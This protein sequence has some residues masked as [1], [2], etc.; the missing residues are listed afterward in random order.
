M[1]YKTNR[2][3][4]IRAFDPLGTVFYLAGLILIANSIE[5]G[6]GETNPGVIIGALLFIP[7][8]YLSSLVTTDLSCNTCTGVILESKSIDQ[9]LKGD[10]LG[11]S[12]NKAEYIRT[13]LSSSTEDSEHDCPDCG[14]K[15]SHI[16]VPIER[17]RRA[18]EDPLLPDVIA[19]WTTK[20]DSVKL[21][22]CKECDLLWF[23]NAKRE[24]KLSMDTAIIPK[25]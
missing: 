24:Q 16:I 10:L 7:G 23:K 8:V 18:Y 22:G 25:T 4:K 6:S 9:K 5:V 2:N 21:D 12:E 13:A 17:E 14:K 11:L 1:E 19:D 15:M 20:S 3:L